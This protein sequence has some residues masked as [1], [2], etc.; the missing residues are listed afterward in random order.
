METSYAGEL[1]N[2]AEFTVMK[3]VSE[4]IVE[5][6]RQMGTPGLDT[7]ADD[8]LRSISAYVSAA[9]REITKRSLSL[10]YVVGKCA[11]CGT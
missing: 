5:E 7:L 2:P 11:F 1:Y 8:L 6:I 4:A 3:K 9:N 10:S